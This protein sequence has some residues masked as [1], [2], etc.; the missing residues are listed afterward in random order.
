MVDNI[1]QWATVATNNQLDS[2]F[3]YYFCIQLR[4]VPYFMIKS[5]ALTRIT[6]NRLDALAQVIDLPRATP[7]N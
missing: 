6:A 4:I 2:V 3:V 5:L 1:Y 7:L